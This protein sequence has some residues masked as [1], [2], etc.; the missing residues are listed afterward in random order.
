[1]T[2]YYE[3]VAG[4]QS[5]LRTGT[6]IRAF[7]GVYGSTA[8]TGVVLAIR[9][10]DGDVDGD[11]DVVQI[12]PVA[13]VRFFDGVY[14]GFEGFQR[15]PWGPFEFED[16]EVICRPSRTRRAWW[17]VRRVLTPRWRR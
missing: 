11:G 5:R 1:M 7:G 15:S 14:E 8:C 13:E 17:A 12:P 9:E 3:Y 6:Y 16:L 10:P 2:D 4:D